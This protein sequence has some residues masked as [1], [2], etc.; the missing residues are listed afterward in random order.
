MGPAHSSSADQPM[1]CAMISPAVGGP[2]SR[3]PS[4]SCSHNTSGSAHG[5]SQRSLAWP[6]R[7]AELT[8]GRTSQRLRP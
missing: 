2:A 3:H 4:W 8:C 6:R 1:R 5:I 7:N